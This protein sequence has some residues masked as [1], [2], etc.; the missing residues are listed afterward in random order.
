M[1]RPHASSPCDPPCVVPAQVDAAIVVQ[2]ACGTPLSLTYYQVAE[3]AAG[4]DSRI[5]ECVE[6]WLEVVVKPALAELAFAVREVRD[7]FDDEGDDDESKK[8]GAEPR[9]VPPSDAPRVDAF[10]ADVG[11]LWGHAELSPLRFDEPRIMLAGSWRAT[12]WIV[13]DGGAPRF[14]L[15]RSDNPD[16]WMRYEPGL[17]TADA[18]RRWWSSAPPTMG[19]PEDEGA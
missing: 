4:G 14:A 12:R 2:A 19:L 11:D 8:D 7:A 15:M 3:L 6:C 16:C 18:V 9:E 17:T 10:T 1:R 5:A 13:T